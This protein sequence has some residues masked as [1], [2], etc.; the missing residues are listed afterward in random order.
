MKLKELQDRLEKTNYTICLYTI[1]KDYKGVIVNTTETEVEVTEVDVNLITNEVGK[2][3]RFRFK[4]RETS[5]ETFERYGN[6]EFHEY[7]C[8]GMNKC[9]GWAYT[10]F[11]ADDFIAKAKEKL[12]KEFLKDLSEGY[13]D[14]MKYFKITAKDL[15][16]TFNIN[17]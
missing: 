15:E 10:A 5:D 6:T 4:N 13:K 17:K 14:R 1:E 9:S 8:D 11:E 3:I 2:N 7:L 16:D 12:K